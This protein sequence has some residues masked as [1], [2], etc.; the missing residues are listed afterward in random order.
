MFDDAVPLSAA[1]LSALKDEMKDGK[2]TLDSKIAAGGNNLSVGERQIIALARAINQRSKVLISDEGQFPG[3]GVRNA[4]LEPYGSSPAA[5]GDW[6]SHA[7]VAG[8]VTEDEHVE[9]IDVI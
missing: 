4:S 9:G 7:A 1:G 3:E 2:L 8:V 5:V 6:E